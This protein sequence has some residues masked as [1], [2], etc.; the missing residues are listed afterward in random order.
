M[1][2]GDLKLNPFLLTYYRHHSSL[3]RPRICAAG[4]APFPVSGAPVSRDPLIA[5]AARAFV[6]ALGLALAAAPAH[7]V[8]PDSAVAEWGTHRITFEEFRVAYLDVLKNPKVFD[9]PKVR[10]SFLNDMITGRVLAEEAE[11]AGRGKNELLA[12]KIRAYQDKCLRDRHFEQVIK[13]KVRVSEQDVE[14]AYLFTQEE[15][16]LSHLFF[17][18]REQADSAFSLLRQGMDFDT[19]A[20]RTFADSALARSGGDL[21]W[22]EWDQLDYDLAMA[23]FRL[24]PPF[25]SKPVKSPFGYHILR[26][27]DFKK[28]PLITRREYE[29]HRRK[30]RY[31]LE[32]K[33]GDK[34]ALEYIRDMGA[35][36][37][38]TY[39][40]EVMG[41][42]DRKLKG[43]F[44]RKPS[45]A[46]QMSEFHLR[47]GE[48]QAI[49]QSL[50]DARSEIMAEINGRPYTVGEFVGALTFLPYNALYNGFKTAFDYAVRDLLLTREAEEKGLGVDAPVVLRT[51]LYKEYL[52][53]LDLRREMVRNVTAEESELKAYYKEHRKTFKGAAYYEVRDFVRDQVIR[54][55]KQRVVPD[56]VA[57]LTRNTPVRKNLDIIN[58]Y[59]DA[60]ARGDRP[61]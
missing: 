53:Q 17:P 41:F 2:W 12:Y 43:Q 23:A 24:R 6:L 18:T 5:A 46:D 29:V 52:Y 1:T 33:L 59:Y 49:E 45:A 50:W 36:T 8:N 9:S 16:R 54:Q 21:G 60:I 28:K 3:V 32:W 37:T 13:P 7:A 47:D 26:V 31:L 56:R 30:A 11:K 4:E 15:R 14:E 57:E 10:E 55:K 25:L 19:L 44:T 58:A 51:N 48:V 61:Q 38:V 34:L 22:V 27:K 42:V 39:R 40:P 20:A 35:R